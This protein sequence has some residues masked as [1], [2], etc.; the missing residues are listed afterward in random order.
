[1]KKIGIFIVLSMVSIMLEAQDAG[2]L[3]QG[4]LNDGN[5]LIKAYLKP[6]NKALIFGLGQNNYNGFENQDGHHWAFGIHSIFLMP[7]DNER[8]YDVNQLGLETLEAEDPHNSL[9][10][11]VLGDSTSYIY[12]VSKR[13]DLLNRPLIKFKSPKGYGYP[14]VAVPYLNL[15]YRSKRG[16]YY[17]GFIPPAPVPTTRLT[18]Y[19]LKGGLQ[20]NIGELL[21]VLNPEKTEWVVN[22]N[23]AYGHG[24]EKLN[25]KPGSVYTAITVT[26][27]LAGPYDNQKLLIDYHSVGAST[28]LVGHLSSSWRLFAGGGATG[29]I[30]NIRMVGRYPIYKAE[31]TGTFAIVAE[32]VDDPLNI[33]TSAAQWFVEGGIRAEWNR[34]YLQL[35]GDYGPYFGGALQLG[36]KFK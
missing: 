21:G 28:F 9:A 12:I 23:Y 31:G 5:K 4:G 15:A 22:L 34:F 36:Y 18:V 30:S 20:W 33:T 3:I 17:L 11:T 16:T 1:M 25:V 32:D 35:Q 10:Q 19:L 27:H 8:V 14:G 26:G 29:G 7:P 2:S 24:F 13:K 6:L